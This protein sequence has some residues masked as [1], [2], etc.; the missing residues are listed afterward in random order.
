MSPPP[1]HVGQV[2]VDLSPGVALGDLAPAVVGLLAPGEPQLQLGMAALVDVEAERDERQPLGL[3]LDRQHVDLVAVEEELA[4]PLRLV[5][6]AIA[7]GP[8]GDMSA[9]QP[10]LAALDPGV[11]LGQAD[12]AGPDRLDLGPAQD[13]ADLQRVLDREL[14][15]GT[16]VDGDGPLA[17][18]VGMAGADDLVAPASRVSGGG[19]PRWNRRSRSP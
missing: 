19:W 12:S 18:G 7:A 17:G 6:E 13:E 16:A 11:R 10:R 4:G 15:A 2:A 14:V 5:V 9:D 8:L 1:V 3:R